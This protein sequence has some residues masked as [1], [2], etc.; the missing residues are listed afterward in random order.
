LKSYDDRNFDAALVEF[1]RAYELAPTF[2]ILYNLG[3][4][5]LELRDYASALD[6]FERY[7]A[8]GVGQISSEQRSE[9]DQ[10]IRDL[11]THIGHV[12]VTVNVDGAEISVDDRVI[13]L[14]PLARPLR[15]NAGAR[16]ISARASG[17]LPDSRVIELAGGDRVQ[18]ALSLIDTWAQPARA[19]PAPQA[20]AAP[21]PLAPERKLPWLP[22]TGTAVLA[23]G[24]V[25]AG[26]QALVA[27]AAYE[28]KL[29][30]A[31]TSRRDLDDAD[32]KTLRW[33][34]AADGLGIAALALGSYSLYLTLRP[35]PPSTA[36]HSAPRMEL[37]LANGLATLRSSF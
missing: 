19:Q 25:F 29:G 36:R 24:A 4:V 37:G 30:E 2:R 33:S 7:L 8:G 14:A 20:H 11:S 34:I 5:S 13:G 3:V 27:Q 18:I 28:E 15:L 21:P 26:L 32:S 17:R 12:A 1:R 16:R 35:G 23:G 6:Y 31:G 22:W 10:K 9:V